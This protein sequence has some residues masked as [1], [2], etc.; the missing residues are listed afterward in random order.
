MSD[1][2]IFDPLKEWKT[3]Q[4]SSHTTDSRIVDVVRFL[5]R[6][7]AEAD[8][9]QH[10]LSTTFLTQTQQNKHSEKER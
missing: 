10:L 4:Q 6:R 8:Y 5:A 7:S 1:K 2:H 3:A 9:Q